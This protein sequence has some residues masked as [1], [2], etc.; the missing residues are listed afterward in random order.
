MSIKS[1]APFILFSFCLFSQSFS[2]ERTYTIPGNFRNA[3]TKL[4]AMEGNENT[5]NFTIPDELKTAKLRISSDL[6]T[7]ELYFIG[8]VHLREQYPIFIGRLGIINITLVR[9]DK[10]IELWKIGPNDIR[11]RARADFQLNNRG[12]PFRIIDNIKNGITD[13]IEEEVLSIEESKLRQ[14]L[15][16]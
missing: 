6:F 13:E 4:K 7:P 8:K 9:A 14:F 12:F 10:S 2:A 15:T 5:T 1:I 16:D 11:V 3:V